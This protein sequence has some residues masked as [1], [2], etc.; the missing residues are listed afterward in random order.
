[1]ALSKWLTELNDFKWFNLLF[2]PKFGPKC[3]QQHDNQ[4]AFYEQN[5][6][7]W[8]MN[9]SQIT[10]LNKIKMQRKLWKVSHEVISLKNIFLK[11]TLY[12]K[13]SNH[14]INY[15]YFK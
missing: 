12:K 2:R 3:W 10:L 8:K 7:M 13:L 15:E 6:E 14:D 4:N 1:M 9:V 11:S 5:V